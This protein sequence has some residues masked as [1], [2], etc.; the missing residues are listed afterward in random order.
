M[1]KI[2]K[3]TER[4]SLAFP[5][6]RSLF[7]TRQNVRLLGLAGTEDIVWSIRLV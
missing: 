7:I 3:P 1:K 2:L 6:Y 4:G 5:L